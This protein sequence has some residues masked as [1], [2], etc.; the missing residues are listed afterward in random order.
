MYKYSIIIIIKNTKKYLRKCLDSIVNQTFKNFEVII[1]DDCS[2]ESSQDIVDQYQLIAVPI[3]Y[4][5]LKKSRNL[6]KKKFLYFNQ[7]ILNHHDL[8]WLLYSLNL[9]PIR[10][11]AV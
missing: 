1:V 6:V 4:I 8:Y 5:F 2:D 9:V 7:Y 3:R 11:V 10:A